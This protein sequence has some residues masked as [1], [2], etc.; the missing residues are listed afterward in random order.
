MPRK[1][2]RRTERIVVRASKNDP[3]LN[4]SQVKNTQQID[5]CTSCYIRKILIKYDFRA[6][7][8]AK[9]P[10]ISGPNRHK[11]WAKKSWSK[12]TPSSGKQSFFGRDYA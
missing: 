5:L 1:V 6:R 12:K 3:F 9:K 4:A 2:Y 11:K 10:S 7:K 8:I